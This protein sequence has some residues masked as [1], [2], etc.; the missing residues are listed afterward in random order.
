ML[1]IK[2]LHVSVAGKNILSGLNLQVNPGEV[3]VVM[4]PN[5][6]GKSTLVNF[7]AGKPDYSYESGSCEFLNNDLLDLSVDQRASQGLFLG[8]QYPVEI[9]GVNNAYFLRTIVNSQRQ[10][11]GEDVIDAYD[12][13]QVARKHLDTLGLAGKDADKFMQRELNVGFSGGEK[14]RNEILQML[15]LQPKLAL[16][17]EIDSGLDIDA[18]QHVATG[19]NDAKSNSTSVLMVTHYQRLLR[20]VHP[21]VVHVFVGGKIVESGGADLANYLEENG[22]AKWQ[23]ELV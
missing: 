2:D 6:G 20:Y 16:L 14:K 21:D 8:F 17:D 13:L 5:G 11:N 19:I 10:A 7:L 4:G 15:C 18:L 9:P 23:S 1:D 12:F 3:H 22:Y